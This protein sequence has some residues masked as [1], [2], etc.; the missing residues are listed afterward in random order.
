MDKFLPL[1]PADLFDK[2]NKENRYKIVLYPFMVTYYLDQ[3]KKY[4]KDVVN[5]NI[6]SLSGKYLK[7]LKGVVE[8][9]FL[10][11]TILD[12]FSTD[13]GPQL[14]ELQIGV[15]CHRLFKSRIPYYKNF[16]RQ[17]NENKDSTTK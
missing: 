10:Q 6:K 11:T 2:F 7:F 1:F 9:E 12:Y 8:N 3:D 13:I 14:H 4:D 17:T 16:S 15:A 5:K